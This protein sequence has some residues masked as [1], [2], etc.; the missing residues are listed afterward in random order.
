MRSAAAAMSLKET[1][2][3]FNH[4]VAPELIGGWVANVH[5]DTVNETHENKIAII[6]SEL[7]GAV[8][9]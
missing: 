5:G 3:L 8:G 9:L 7:S 6:T 4:R 2:L 1:R